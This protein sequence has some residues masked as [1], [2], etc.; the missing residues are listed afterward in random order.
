MKKAIISSLIVTLALS[1]LYAQSDNFKSGYILTNQG[2]TL[3]GRIDLRTNVINQQQCSFLP[4][5]SSEALIYK[6][7]E[8]D[9]YVFI[10][11]GKY[12]VSKILEIKGSRLKVFAEFLVKGMLN[13]YYYEDKDDYYALN[14]HYF[15]YKGFVPYY[16]FENEDGNTT[17]ISNK[18][19][20]V[21]FKADNNAR[22]YNVTLPDNK[23]KG[24]IGYSFKDIKPIA[25]NYEN[26]IFNQKS[27]ITVA[28][29][30]HAA[31]CT[32]GEE[33]IVFQN[34]NPDKFGLIFQV[35]PYI[36][37]QNATYNYRMV[38]EKRKILM[39]TN[40]TL[41]PVGGIELSLINP[42]WTKYFAGQ[43]DLSLSY[44]SNP[45][46]TIIVKPFSINEYYTYNL[47]QTAYSFSTL[48]PTIHAGIQ[49]VFPKY[50]F[51]P[52]LGVGVSYSTFLNKRQ[53]LEGVYMPPVKQQHFGVYAYTGFNYQLKNNHFLIFRL[54]CDYTLSGDGMQWHGNDN[55]LILNTK[56]GYTL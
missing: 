6:P 21:Y 37:F 30:Y 23:Y 22:G 24:I 33:C 45:K 28:R 53:H 26:I 31:V 8:I 55:M 32:T 12:Y 44:F 4:N 2:D 50:K 56:I 38:K 11:D 10:D 1:T 27:F 54:N 16:F 47:T 14:N 20:S 43:I 42:R 9:G 40:S 36:G 41:S 52:V 39:Y 18:P 19:D 5:G 35:A 49:F 25:D 48:V 3:F 34:P 17:V 46:D 15:N 13:L 29:Q 7:F 51:R